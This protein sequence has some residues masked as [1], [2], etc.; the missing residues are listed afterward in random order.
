ML[1]PEYE[2]VSVVIPTRNRQDR[3]KKALKSAVDQTWPK[4]E[5]IVVDD[6]SSDGTGSFLSRLASS[7]ARVHVIKNDTARGGGWS[8]NQGVDVAK[9]AYI[10]FL[11]D[12]D[13]WFPE[14]VTEQVALLKANPEASAVSC[15]FIVQ[16]SSLVQRTVKVVQPM[17]EQQILKSNHLGGASMCLTTKKTFVAVGGFDPLLRSGQ[18]WDL[19][20]K[21]YRAGNVLI[22]DQP[23]V[24]YLPHQGPRITTNLRAVYEGRRRIFFRYKMSMSESTRRYL[25]CE[26]MFCRKVLLSKSLWGRYLGLLSVLKIAKETQRVRYI[27]RFLKFVFGASPYS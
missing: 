17:D 20:I 3:L 9:G 10:A 14:K 19:W 8:R 25:L 24:Q 13:I 12:D 11:D 7:D 15:N 5:I 4:I 26:L 22:S 27:Y 2:L 23:L 1:P 6:G 18:D 21:L 16:G